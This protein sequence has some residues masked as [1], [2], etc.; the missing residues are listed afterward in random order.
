MGDLGAAAS[1][2]APACDSRP[3][4]WD[5]WVYPDR[6]NMTVSMSL[7]GFRTFEE[8][9]QAAIDKLRSL[10]DPEQGDYECGYK[11]RFDPSIQTNVCKETKK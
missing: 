7:V 3:D 11:C 10:S 6:E 1:V 4:S 9:Q 2:V 8:C 5:A